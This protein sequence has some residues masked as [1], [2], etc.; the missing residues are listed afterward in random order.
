MLHVLPAGTYGLRPAV[1]RSNT[2]TRCGTHR[3]CVYRWSCALRCTIVYRFVPPPPP[4][5]SPLSSPRWSAI[6]DALPLV[7]RPSPPLFAGTTSPSDYLHLSYP[8][9]WCYRRRILMHS[10]APR[11]F[12]KPSAACQPAHH[13]ENR[14]PEKS[15]EIDVFQA[16]HFDEAVRYFSFSARR[17]S[18]RLSYIAVQYPV[19]FGLA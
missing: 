15:R 10:P 8:S 18:R 13:R 9:R 5:P 17:Y 11:S 12:P 6:P 19:S 1:N 3:V 14:V 4:F 2:R 16:S 7:A